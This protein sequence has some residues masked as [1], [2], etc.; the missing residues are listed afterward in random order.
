M[1]AGVI[2]PVD[3]LIASTV[4]T[5]TKLVPVITTLVAVFSIVLGLILDTVGK[6]RAACRPVRLAPYTAGSVAGN[7]ASGSVPDVS[8]VALSVVSPEPDPDRL[9]PDVIVIVSPDSPIVMDDPVY[10]FIV[11]TFTSDILLCRCCYV[12]GSD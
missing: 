9:A 4:G 11:F 7:L 8:C 12:I 5:D 6:L 3:E 10:F 1:F 2:A